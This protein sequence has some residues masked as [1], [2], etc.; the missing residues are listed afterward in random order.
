VLLEQP[1]IAQ[2][3]ITLFKKRNTVI[4]SWIIP[5]LSRLLIDNL[6][7]AVVSMSTIWPPQTLMKQIE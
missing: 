5:T 7:V 3:T 6:T 4:I 1:C 2:H